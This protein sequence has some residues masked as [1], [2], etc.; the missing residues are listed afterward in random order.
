[1]IQ[2]GI[3]DEVLQTYE[4]K[5]KIVLGAVVKV[6][7]FFHSKIQLLFRIVSLSSNSFLWNVCQNHRTKLLLIAMAPLCWAESSSPCLR[8]FRN[9]DWWNLFSSQ[10]HFGWRS[11]RQGKLSH[12]FFKRKHTQYRDRTEEG[13]G[14]FHVGRTRRNKFMCEGNNPFIKLYSTFSLKS[15]SYR[16]IFCSPIFFLLPSKI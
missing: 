5:M 12:G 6:C 8:M 4:V 1:M 14:S 10:T 7:F 11:R 9:P 15:L 3:Y 13:S 16:L 2:F